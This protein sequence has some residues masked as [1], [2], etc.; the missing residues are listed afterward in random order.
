MR[1]GTALSLSISISPVRRNVMQM[2]SAE[3]RL[4]VSA[5]DRAK[6]TVHPELVISTRR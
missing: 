4:F 3:K 1:C 5:L 6:R 2:S